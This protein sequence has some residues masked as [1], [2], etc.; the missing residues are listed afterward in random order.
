M[1]DPK[2][3]EDTMTHLDDNLHTLEAF[4][5][6]SDGSVVVSDDDDEDDEY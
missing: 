1:F 5:Q 3:V 2:Y 6:Q 4:L